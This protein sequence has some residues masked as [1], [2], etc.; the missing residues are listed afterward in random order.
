MSNNI[1]Y[2]GDIFLSR[3]EVEKITDLSRSEI[4]ELMKRDLFPH[5]YKRSRKK[6][7]WSAREIEAY[8]ESIKS[9][10]DSKQV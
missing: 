8:I 10:Q 5:P 2:N 7:S 6:V 9:F 3:K 4:Y 1:L